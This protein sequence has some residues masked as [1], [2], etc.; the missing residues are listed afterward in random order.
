MSCIIV[1]MPKT[2]A[3]SH[4]TAIDAPPNVVWR[5]ITEVDITT[6][7]HPAYLRLLDVPKPLRAEIIDAGVGGVRIAHFGNGR[8]FSQSITT[9]QPNVHYA[10]TFK[11][12]KGFRVG[13][14]LDLADG[15]FQMKAGSYQIDP[16]SGGVC[17][18]LTS[19]YQLSGVAGALLRL[20]VRVVLEFFQ[21]YLLRGIKANAERDAAA[22]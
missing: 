16:T 13:Y 2:Y 9:W 17:L 20:P 5:H 15:S 19:H 14:L 11:A 10:F 6:F 8:R 21:R 18:T 4:K 12:D 22:L 7:N 3:L 1:N